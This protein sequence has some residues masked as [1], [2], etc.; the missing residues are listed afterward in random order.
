MISPTARAAVLREVD[1]DYGRRQITSNE[2]LDLKRSI[3]R[4]NSK[5][6][7]W[8]VLRAHR[9]ARA[10]PAPV[11]TAVAAVGVASLGWIGWRLYERRK[12]VQMLSD[13]TNPLHAALY[14]LGHLHGTWLHFFWEEDLAATEIK[15]TNMTTAQQGYDNLVARTPGASLTDKIT[16]TVDSFKQAAQEG[17]D[18]AQSIVKAWT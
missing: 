14:K 18:F 16:D 5:Q 15:Y 1:E 13:E 8:E 7:A 9:Q 6:E 11:V 10:N 2:K 12:L 4:A 17:R 3:Q